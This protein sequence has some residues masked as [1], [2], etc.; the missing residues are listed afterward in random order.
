MYTLLFCFFTDWKMPLKL[1][2]TRCVSQWN[3]C[4]IGLPDYFSNVSFLQ[5]FDT[6]HRKGIRSVK[7]ALAIQVGSPM[8]M[9]PNMEWLRKKRTLKRTLGST[10]SSALDVVGNAGRGCWWWS[11]SHISAG[12]H[13]NADGDAGTLEPWQ[14]HTDTATS[15][16]LPSRQAVAS[17]S[18]RDIH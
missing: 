10:V 7:P 16:A 12:D 17:V 2:C 3:F 5:C 13:S 9:R 4:L 15:P 8:E 14:P 18:C 6:V 11:I 1:C